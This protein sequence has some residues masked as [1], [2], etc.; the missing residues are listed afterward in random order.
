MIDIHIPKARQNKVRY[1]ILS[2]LSFN[3]VPF[4]DF[5]DSVLNIQ[6]SEKQESGKLFEPS[7]SVISFKLNSDAVKN[8]VVAI[9]D[10]L[11][12]KVIFV[13]QYIP[14]LNLSSARYNG[15]TLE[16]YLNYNLDNI[17]NYHS[18][19]DLLESIHDDNAES[20][21]LYS[22]KEHVLHK[23]HKHFVLFKENKEN[24]VEFY[25]L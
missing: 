7:R 19:Y 1:V 10:L 2:A 18:L 22:D 12:R 17:L 6:F 11:N 21:I 15:E 20:K 14:S 3:N 16:K 5:E 25:E 4:T 23:N 24:D 8:K 9:F 13:D